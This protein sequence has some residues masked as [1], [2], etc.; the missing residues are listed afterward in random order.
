M[1]SI[2][3]ADA[4]PLHYLILIDCAGILEKL[5]DQVLI[6]GAV[7]DEMLQ[8]NTPPKVKTWMLHPP[9]W[10][11][12]EMVTNVQPIHGLHPGEIEALQLALRA[13]AAGVLMD[14]MDG[15]KAARQLGLSVVG[16]IGLLERAAEKQLIEFPSAIARLRQTNFFI[17]AEFLDQA[18]ER[19]RLRRE[20]TRPVKNDPGIKP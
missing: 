3:V 13:K 4:G 9:A 15:R 12:V 11:K 1:T 10:L 18:L 19:D 14:D 17:S 2:V 20:Q 5:F 7:R 8:P 6:P 16:T